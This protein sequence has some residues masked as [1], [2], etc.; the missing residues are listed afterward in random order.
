MPKPLRS[1]SLSPFILLI[2]DDKSVITTVKNNL[3]TSGVLRNHLS[4]CQSIKEATS[5]LK[6]HPE[7]AII[8]L[9]ASLPDGMGLDG[10]KKLKAAF[11]DKIIIVLADNAHQ[12]LGI[13]FIRTGAQDF[14]IKEVIAHTPIYPTIQLAVERMRFIKQEMVEKVSKIKQT[15]Q[16]LYQDI[17]NQSK[18]A[19]YICNL[20]GRLVD[21]N[22]AT[23]ELFAFSEE[24][25]L[26][27]EIH[28]LFH[29]KEKKREFLYALVSNKSVTEFPMEIE[30]KNGKI[31][32][33]LISASMIRTTEFT[34]YSGLL[35][36]ITEQKKANDLRKARDIARQSAK[37]KE[38]FIANISH[39]MRTP[40]NAILGMSNLAIQTNLSKE[41]Y[42]YV[43]SIKQSSEVLLGVVNDILVISE[44]QNSQLKFDYKFFDLNELLHNL[45]NLV[46][47]KATEKGLRLS[48][49]MKEGIPKIVQGDKLRLN[50]ILYNLVLNAIKFTAKG[51]VNIL[52]ENQNESNDFVQLK[53]TIEDTGIGIPL[54]KIDAI[55]ETF[56]LI[57]EQGMEQEGKGLGLPIAKNLVEQQGGK[58]GVKSEL[59]R[60]SEFYFDLLFEIGEEVF[61]EPIQAK[62]A[63][64]LD[65]GAIRVLLVEDHKMNQL[66]AIKTL[67]KHWSDIEI[68]VANDGQEGVA[69]L[70]EKDF[71]IILMDIQMPNMNGY[72]ATRYI[73]HKMLPEK[74]EIP[75][76]AMTAHAHVAKNEKFREYGM[77]D[78][79][80]K[81]FEPKELFR[82]ITEYTFKYKVLT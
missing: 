4:A 41:Q 28:N 72:E 6:A 79:I 10:L 53:F 31:R 42:S 36:D 43:S 75:I 50:Q 66:V 11:S 12:Y 82:K 15:N 39:E 18:D 2:E 29:T 44:I 57:R 8:L 46:Q 63:A 58:I 19:I 25:L 54:D 65:K 35:R 60:G 13:D 16:Q 5:F 20:E 80:L 14:I 70:A 32:K 61:P 52:V 48:L 78:C 69:I 74:A 45:I 24:E 47:F 76:L 40:M 1:Q 23:F 38:Q 59:G 26:E 34:G 77:D 81:P 68:T 51:R 30:Q 21:F 56:T 67:E 22:Q 17:F 9:D 55:F 62:A 73:R 64:T 49:Q 33:C 37:M 7:F 71:D 3:A 27:I